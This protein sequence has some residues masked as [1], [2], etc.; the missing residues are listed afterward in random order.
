MAIPMTAPS[1]KKDSKMKLRDCSPAH[2]IRKRI[3]PLFVTLIGLALNGCA[4]PPGLIDP[5]GNEFPRDAQAVAQREGLDGRGVINYE[6]AGGSFQF[7]LATFGDSSV[8]RSAHE[9]ILG[10]AKRSCDEIGG[11]LREDSLMTPEMLYYYPGGYDLR[12]L[13][14]PPR[15]I[16]RQVIRLPIDRASFNVVACDQTTR[17]LYIS[18]MTSVDAAAF[19]GALVSV[20]ASGANDY[21]ETIKTKPDSDLVDPFDFSTLLKPNESI[22]QK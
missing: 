11:Q 12:G 21:N 19:E 18:V 10:A 2:L 9:A 1:K 14:P 15:G 6:G 16:E 4:E 20:Q 22:S 7:E 5:G 3:V 8:H 17:R 13:N